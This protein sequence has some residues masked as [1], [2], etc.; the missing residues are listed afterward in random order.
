[1]HMLRLLIYSCFG[2][3]LGGSALSQ[4]DPS[5]FQPVGPC[6]DMCACGWCPEPVSPP[7]FP[8][9]H[10]QQ[11]PSPA[12][13]AYDGM[14][15]VPIE[16]GPGSVLVESPICLV[17]PCAC[18]FCTE[19]QP[20]LEGVEITVPS[21]V[22]EGSKVP[23]AP[24][25]MTENLTSERAPAEVDGA[26]GGVI[27]RVAHQR[28]Q[29]LVDRGS[30]C[31]DQRIRPWSVT[32]ETFLGRDDLRT[33]T[34]AVSAVD[35][36]LDSLWEEQGLPG[37]RGAALMEVQDLTN[38][39]FQEYREAA[40]TVF[41]EYANACLRNLDDL[42]GFEE[43][44]FRQ[45]PE[46]SNMLRFGTMPGTAEALFES[47]GH[48]SAPRGRDPCSAVLVELDDQPHLVTAAHCLGIETS[49]EGVATL[50]EV[51]PSLKFISYTGRQILFDV[52]SDLEGLEYD[53]SRED[54]IATPVVLRE[55]VPL[56]SVATTPLEPWE[57]MLIVGRSP[58]L[59][60]FA[61]LDGLEGI[62]LVRAATSATLSAHCRANASEQGAL[63]Y[64][65]QTEGGTSGAPIFAWRDGRLVLAGL[66]L[67]NT[68]AQPSA[69]SCTGGSPIGGANRGLALRGN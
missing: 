16:T 19:D 53:I 55:P 62:D 3:A 42:V 37:Q 43:T 33:C 24:M 30:F 32:R 44:G 51:W 31:P 5:I 38:P 66:H 8:P 21:I 22:T 6:V 58:Y 7:Q 27:D 4:T 60:A 68:G 1:M 41:G 54:I 2:M 10:L 61:R 64:Y 28:G 9:L 34:A 13:R 23:F 18:G 40:S 65:C 46:K 67:G 11:M 14:S 36:F 39:D 56:L 17:D 52:S 63:R 49:N 35:A 20:N 25:S 50:S 47:I 26:Q 29:A 15:S 69:I 45:E 48:L 59:E 57:A 12:I